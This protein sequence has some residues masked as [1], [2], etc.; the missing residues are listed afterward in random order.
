MPADAILVVAGV[1][2]AF[3]VFAVVLAW[4]NHTTG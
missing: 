4:V 1:S 2:A 3:F